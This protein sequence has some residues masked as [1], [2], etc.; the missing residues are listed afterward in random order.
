MPRV[1]SRD[2]IDRL[3]HLQRAHCDI[4]KIADRRSDDVKHGASSD[5]NLM[6][7]RDSIVP[8]QCCTKPSR[9]RDANYR[10]GGR[11]EK[12]HLFVGACAACVGWLWQRTDESNNHDNYP[13]SDHNRPSPRGG[14]GQDSASS[15]RGGS[16]RGAWARIYMDEGL[17]AMDRN[18]LCVGAR[19]LGG[20]AQADRGMGGK[21]LGASPRWLG[22]AR[23]SLAV[24]VNRVTTNVGR[25]LPE[26][27]FKLLSV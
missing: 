3:Q 23:G 24:V 26:G 11:H 13:G 14:G 9:R 21:P 5:R 6:Y 8:R 7:A 2:H 20:A 10:K 19:D 16:N 25:L 12:K 4:A 27:V 18:R 15:S 22:V 17:L 1:F